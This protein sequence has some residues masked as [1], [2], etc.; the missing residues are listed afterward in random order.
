MKCEPDYHCP[1]P[2][3]STPAWRDNGIEVRVQFPHPISFPG[4]TYNYDFDYTAK[5]MAF[6]TIK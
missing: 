6:L 2:R 5:S 3:P 4:Y 1:P